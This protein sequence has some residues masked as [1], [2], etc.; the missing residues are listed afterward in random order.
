MHIEMLIKEVRQEKGMTISALSRRSGVSAAHLSDIEK[1]FKSPSLLVM[2]R[3]AKAL[4]VE[5]TEL[6]RVKW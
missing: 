4:D 6:Y 2:V 5:I 1:N 3:I